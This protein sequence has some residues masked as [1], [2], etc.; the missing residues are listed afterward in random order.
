MYGLPSYLGVL[1]ELGIASLPGILNYR[2]SESTQDFH[3]YLYPATAIQIQISRLDLSGGFIV[4]SKH[5]ETLA[6]I[7]TT[8]F[9]KAQP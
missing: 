8:R 4:V 2:S 5:H 9:L 1:G 3:H 6:A 7:T